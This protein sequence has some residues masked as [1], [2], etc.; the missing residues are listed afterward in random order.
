MS[1]LSEI[2]PSP[3]AGNFLP[4]TRAVASVDLEMGQFV[5]SLG[6]PERGK[7]RIAVVATEDEA[8]ELRLFIRQQIDKT[9]GGCRDAERL[10]VTH[11]TSTAQEER[12]V[13]IVLG[14]T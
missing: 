1:T 3:G 9:A 13:M 7:T 8:K 2:F 12:V 5:C 10:G 11:W 6:R 4:V 14:F